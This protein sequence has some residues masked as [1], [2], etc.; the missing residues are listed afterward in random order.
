MRHGSHP[1]R[2]GGVG[3]LPLSHPARA[4][5]PRQR[6]FRP[7]WPHAYISSRTLKGLLKIVRALQRVAVKKGGEVRRAESSL[8]C[9]PAMALA[10]SARSPAEGV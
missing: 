4:R 1:R 5:M 6:I 2:R 8:D 7:T 3:T 9:A 10:E